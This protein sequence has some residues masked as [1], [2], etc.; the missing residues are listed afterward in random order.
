MYE[1][2]I[3]PQPG[4]YVHFTSLSVEEERQFVVFEKR[5]REAA[6]KATWLGWGISAGITAVALLVILAFWAPLKPYGAEGSTEDVKPTTTA[7]GPSLAPSVAPTAPT[8]APTDP[9]APGGTAAPASGVAPA[10]TAPAPTDPAAAPATPPPA[11]PAPAPGATKAS[12][13]QLTK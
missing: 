2:L 7:P 10:G 1:D 3:P 8:P 5:T 11:A 13:T 12:P 9:A 6:V 4:A